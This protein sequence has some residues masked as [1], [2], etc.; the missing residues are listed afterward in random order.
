MLK[1]LHRLEA[2]SI[3]LQNKTF[4]SSTNDNQSSKGD[5]YIH[6]LL[7][8]TMNLPYLTQLEM[9]Y[10]STPSEQSNS[11]LNSLTTILKDLPQSN[12]TEASTIPTSP[13]TITKKKVF[14]IVYGLFS[15]ELH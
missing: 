5:L 14:F 2:F 11:F 15:R 3:S 12:Q 8:K 6:D 10:T 13:T 9:N 7:N 1:E 4:L